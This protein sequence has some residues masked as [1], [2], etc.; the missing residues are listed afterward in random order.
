MLFAVDFYEYLIEVPLPLCDLSQTLRS[1]LPALRR[2]HRINSIPPVTDACV[3]NVD[4][5]FVEQILDIA[6]RQ[7]ETDIH[8]HRKPNN[9]RRRV[10]VAEWVLDHP[11][12]LGQG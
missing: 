2:E 10:E 5:A 8:H 9:F 3:T 7:W 1:F 4:P 11:K 12:M 6:E